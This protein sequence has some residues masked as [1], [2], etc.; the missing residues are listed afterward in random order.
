MPTSYT[1]TVT[2]KD[3][4]AAGW[5][6]QYFRWVSYDAPEPI[7]HTI[8]NWDEA[9]GKFTASIMLQD[10]VYGLT[11][12][13]ALAGR[14]VDVTLTP[15]PTIT[16][17]AGSRWPFKVEVPRDRTQVLRVRYFRVGANQ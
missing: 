5:F 7:V 13:A 3:G 4:T 11:C 6:I 8:T 10:G 17:P 1:V 2:P 16:Q 9:D 14:K 15:E 12:Q